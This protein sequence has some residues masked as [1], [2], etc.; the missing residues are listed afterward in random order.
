MSKIKRIFVTH[1]RPI[2]PAIFVLIAFFNRYH[3]YQPLLRRMILPAILAAVVFS[4]TGLAQETGR[5]TGKVTDSQGAVIPGASVTIRSI[6]TGAVRALETNM[7]GIYIVTNLQPGIYEVQVEA[8]GF[9]TNTE[10]VNVTVG[11]QLSLTTQLTVGPVTVGSIAVVAGG[12]VDV[13]TRNQELSDVFLTAQVRELP[14]LT[15]NP[16]DLVGLSGNV[17][18]AGV[19]PAGASVGFSNTRGVGYSINGQRA[20]GTG[21]LLDGAQNVDFFTTEVGQTVP[22]DSV[23][24]FRVITSDFSS[25]YGRATGGI[26]NVATKTGTNEF[27]GTVYE[28]YRG[29]ALASNTFENN[30]NSVPKGNFVRNQFG[31]STGGPALKD[32]L[33]FFVNPEWVRL[34]NTQQ[35]I[36]LVPTP[37]FLART[38]GST[39]S[40][41]NTFPLQTQINGPIFTVG[42]VARELSLPAGTAFTSLPASLPAFGQVRYNLPSDIDGEIAPTATPQNTYNIIGRIDWNKSQRTQLYGRYAI[43]SEDFF[44]GTNAFSPYQGF[45]T[46]EKVFNQNFLVNLTYT[47][48]PTLV[49][50]SKFSFNRLNDSQPL[51][52]RPPTPTLYLRT[53][54][55]T[56]GGFDVALPGYLP[57]DPG[58]AIP[59]GGPQNLY[60]V[61]QDFNNTRGNHQ[62]RYGGSYIHIQDN[63]TFGAFENAAQ[64][65]GANDSQALDNMVDGLL[66][67]FQTAVNPQGKFPGETISLPVGQP[68]F[69]RSNRYN[70]FSLYGNDTWRIKPRLSLNLGLRYDY[71]GV[72]HNKDQQLDSNFYF[73]PGATI[74]EQIRTGQVFIAP[75]SPVG[76]LWEKDKNN[77][78]P[79]L[80]IAW[81]IFG[82]G[83]TSLRGGYG[84]SYDRNFGNVTFNVIQN[85]PAYAVLAITAGATPGF[86]VGSLPVTS[87]NLGPFQGSGTEVL[88]PPTS[89]RHVVQNIGTA[90]AHFWSASL[91]HEVMPNIV[92][93]INY[94]GSAGRN[95]YSI[96][97]TNRPGSGAVYLGDADT[98]SRLNNQY[99]GINSRGFSGRSNYNAMVLELASNRLSNWGLQFTSRYTYSHSLDNLSTAFSEAANNFNLGLLDPF[100]PGLDY[101][102]SDFDTRQRFANSFSWEVQ[103]QWFKNNMLRHVVGGWQLTGILVFQT[104][105]PFT[106]F[107]CT[108]AATAESSCPRLIPTAPI[109]FS[110]PNTTP[111][112][113]NIPNRFVY[114]NLADQTPGPFINPIT[115]DSDFGPYPSNMTTRNAF[116]GPGYWNIDIGIYKNFRIKERYD[117][118]FR[119]EFYN[120]FNNSNLFIRGNEA[121]INTGFVPAFRSGRRAIQ[122]ALKFIF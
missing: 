24:E 59:F 4:I 55:M 66:S 16:Y 111:S 89:L 82:T 67:S 40:F 90:Y 26:I 25:E 99:T 39:Q 10:R 60:S 119:S 97:N 61:Y 69:S 109:S 93:S 13:N 42:D 77:F 94:T 91:Q 120:F 87:N 107:D 104:G 22:L 105:T 20:S 50:Q 9:A 95:L 121:E 73:G 19:S 8:A 34:R 78:A 44:P 122:L 115:G 31:F 33:F 38:A 72:Q 100:D 112:V 43:L 12:T 74:Q 117:L 36:N 92:A 101:G 48:S 85:P 15:R 108:N 17:A 68:N 54:P 81:D 98:A 88:L 49:S 96:E 64:T 71:F 23:Q 7:E 6:D 52:E 27:H 106:V 28:F 114:T 18:P 11:S 35:E 21:I 5:I 30:A 70:E 103:S 113:P 47:F 102:S 51:G 53:I 62:L 83:K 56:I 116:S 1:G 118:Q 84:I 76:G 63:R 29:S 65:L 32:K 79:R 2:F 110:Q 41:F 37:E 58:S 80:G 45:N 86:P 75:D 3:R 57:F 14:T 46:G